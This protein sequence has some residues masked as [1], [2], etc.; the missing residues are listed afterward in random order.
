MC[1][2]LFNVSLRDMCIFHIIDIVIFNESTWSKSFRINSDKCIDDEIKIF[3]R[4]K[5]RDSSRETND[6]LR[7]LSD[8]KER[9]R[10]GGSVNSMKNRSVDEGK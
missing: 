1:V 8:I 3:D 7:N 2:L 5:K 4:K 9:E 10:K 6:S